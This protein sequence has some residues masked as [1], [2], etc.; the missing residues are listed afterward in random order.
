M[1]AG[2]VNEDGVP[3]VQLQI[4]GQNW[5]AIVDT[6]FNGELELPEVLRS[7]VNP[8]YVGSVTSLLAAN[9]QIQED[10]YLVDFVFDGRPIRSEATF[11][12]GNEILIGTGLLWDYRIQIDF[13]AR[14]IVI[15]TA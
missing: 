3:T 11:A 5:P 6:G 2:V 14:V 1:I 8:Q 7:I 4:G 9:Q 13:P 15:E 12:N 10:V